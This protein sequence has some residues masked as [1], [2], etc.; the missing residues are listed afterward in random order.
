MPDGSTPISIPT[1]QNQHDHFALKAG[2]RVTSQKLSG[3][4]NTH[5]GNDVNGQYFSPN[6]SDREAVG[7]ARVNVQ[8]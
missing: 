5:P 1:T 7:G 3:I 6:I 2:D 8:S 4:I